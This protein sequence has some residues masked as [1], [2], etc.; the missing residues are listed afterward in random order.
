M[1]IWEVGNEACTNILSILSKLHPWIED[2][3][4]HV[5]KIYLSILSKLHQHKVCGTMEV[6]VTK[7]SILSELHQEDVCKDRA[8]PDTTFNS[9]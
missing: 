4:V 3:E 1:G 5:L 8:V 6:N 7:L 9:F 2:D